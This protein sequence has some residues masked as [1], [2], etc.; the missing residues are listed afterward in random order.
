MT[1]YLEAPTLRQEEAMADT[2]IAEHSE[3]AQH[4]F[5]T[6]MH[7]LHKLTKEKD[8]GGIT[9]TLDKIN[10]NMPGG[11]DGMG[12]LGALLAAQNA[13]NGGMNG[14]WPVLLLA[15]LRNGNGGLFGGD[16]NGASAL[17]DTSILSGVN[18]LQAAV[19][20]SA[21]ETQ[22]AILQSQNAVQSSIAGTSAA[23]AG[24]IGDTK[25][26]VT[27]SAALLLQS[28]NTNTQAI[29]QAVA[30]IGSKIDANQI[31]DLQR[32]LG[33]AQNAAFEERLSARTRDVEVN[34]TQSVNQQQAQAQLQAQMGGL[35]SLVHGLAAQV[36]RSN[37]DVVNLGT[38]IGNT[39]SSA[40]TNVR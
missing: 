20:N 4:H 34:V 11:G 35:V 38:M 31:A 9:E 33:V 40:N 16:G 7:E 2:T 18:N 22:N 28:G 3:T 36:N 12:G 1:P 32:Q 21:L 27:N 37:Q 39:Q 10:I 17:L 14:I 15:L 30:G 23:L 6:L 8:M 13:N 5:E 26:A 29:L 19:P 25:D 24:A